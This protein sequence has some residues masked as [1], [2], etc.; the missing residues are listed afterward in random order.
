VQ[1]RVLYKGHDKRRFEQ[2][3]A[4]HSTRHFMG[5]Y[6]ALIYSNSGKV[7]S[8]IKYALFTNAYRMN[9]HILFTSMFIY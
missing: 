4:K 7:Y 9:F 6:V 3:C 8:E 1:D 2:F 5:I